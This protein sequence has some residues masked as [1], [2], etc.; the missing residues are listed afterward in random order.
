MNCCGAL[1]NYA[2]HPAAGRGALSLKAKRCSA[3]AV[4]E[5]ER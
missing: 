4:G 3:P 5:R 2:L 1:S